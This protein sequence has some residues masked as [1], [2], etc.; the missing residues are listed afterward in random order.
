MILGSNMPQ[1]AKS[2]QALVSTRELVGETLLKP[3]F[4]P[5]P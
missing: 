2:R 1:S 3:F 5:P 4:P